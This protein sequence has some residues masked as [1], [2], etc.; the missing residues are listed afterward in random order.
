MFF[1]VYIIITRTSVTF[2]IAFS[3]NKGWE[4]EEDIR[5]APVPVIEL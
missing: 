3:R 5:T 4:N 1:G 2:Y